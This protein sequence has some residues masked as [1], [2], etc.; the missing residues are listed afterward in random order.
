MYVETDVVTASWLAYCG[1]CIGC[2]FPSWLRR[3]RVSV[4]GP[5][6][7]PRAKSQPT[8]GRGGT[9]HS[10]C[11][12]TP[13]GEAASWPAASTG[14]LGA[15]ATGPRLDADSGDKIAGDS[16]ISGRASDRQGSSLSKPG[17]LGILG[18]LEIL[19]GWGVHGTHR[20]ETE[21]HLTSGPTGSSAAVA[22]GA[23]GGIIP[24]RSE[25]ESGGLCENRLLDVGVSPVGIAN[26]IRWP[27]KISS[28]A[29]RP[30]W[31]RAPCKRG[32]ESDKRLSYPPRLEHLVAVTRPWQ[33]CP[34]L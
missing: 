20:L 2:W 27:D 22:S 21:N 13:A 6:T 31:L 29:L 1:W 11:V 24:D 5:T 18:I 30:M 16:Q 7:T 34:K 33:N 17:I 26:L 4:S 28:L 10:L 23:K 32:G 12:I 3:T 9:T 15:S 19:G 14:A 8:L 25:G